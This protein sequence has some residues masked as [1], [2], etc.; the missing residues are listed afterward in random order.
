MKIGLI[1]LERSGK[2]TLFNALTG[3]A[4]EV[5]AF[6]RRKGKPNVGVAFVADENVESLVRLYHPKKTTFASVEFVD[7]TGLSEG[8]AREGGLGG[9][10]AEMIRTAD[11]LAVVL[12]N[13][14]DDLLG[15]PAPE[16]DF[17]VLRD[18]LLLADLLIVENRLGRIAWALQR[19]QRS[20]RLLREQVLLERV[21][22]ALEAGTAIR[23]METSAD[24]AAVLRSFHFLTARPALVILNSDE[25]SF[26]RDPALLARLRS[27]GRAVEFAGRFE[28]ELARLDDP[29]DAEAFLED[30]GIEASA[31]ALLTRE[32]YALLERISFYTVGEDEVRAWTLRCGDTAY[33]AA[34]AIHSDLARGFIRA[35]CSSAEDLLA[36]GSEKAVKDA[37][38]LRLEGRNYVVRPGDV[39]SIRFSV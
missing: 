18:E 37:G 29:R 19:G 26:G 39:L 34:G 33:A 23:A 13:F 35:E 6:S 14:P 28:M 15:A 16:T 30:M 25:N 3:G 31:R 21:R 27:G 2:T 11:A 10:A 4:A 8:M 20:D 9:A 38:R 1:G 7:F 22:A 36:L 24:E 32:A 5:N 17:A 12:R